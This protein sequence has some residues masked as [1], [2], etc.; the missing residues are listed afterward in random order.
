M[1]LE[2]FSARQISHMQATT[3]DYFLKGP[4]FASHIKEKPLLAKMEGKT[5]SYTGAKEFISVGVRMQSGNNGVNDRITGMGPEDTVGFYNPANGLRAN[6]VPRE[7]HIGWK[8]SESEL[9]K[10]G[11]LVQDQPN[12][13]GSGSRAAEVLAPV[14]EEAASDFAEQYAISMNDLLWGD[15]TADTS[16]LHG[17]RSFILDIPTIGTVGGLTNAAYPRWRNYAFTAA[18]N[19]HSTFDADF[20]GNAI[21]SNV[22]AG[23][24]LLQALTKLDRKLIKY[25]GRYDCIYCG[26]DFLDAMQKEIRANGGYSDTGFAQKQD[27]SMGEMYFK[28]RKVV[29][30]P[31][32]D[33]LGLSKR[34][35]FWDPEDIKLMPL[36]GDWKRRRTPERPYNQ[37]V[38]HQ[39][40]ICTGQMTARRRNSAAVVDIA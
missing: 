27:G 16:A 11:I 32:L 9:K 22:A 15:G 38:F 2:G 40:L 31:T 25:G 7:H 39:S 33:D 23:G 13:V 21:T 14:L 24:A 8:M 18:F 30:D 36:K 28:G 12:K 4:L 19:G 35:Y 1:S 26:D 5:K 29:Y 20:G 34:A 37:F 3:L 10:Q 17:I 6:Y